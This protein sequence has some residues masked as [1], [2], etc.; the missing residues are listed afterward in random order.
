MDVTDCTSRGFLFLR[1]AGLPADGPPLHAPGL[2]TRVVATSDLR[3]ELPPE[4]VWVDPAR[5]REIHD[6]R[7]RDH[8]Q[9]FDVLEPK[10]SP[11]A[12]QT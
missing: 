3:Q 6:A 1:W 7:E 4:T 12:K 8:A 10:S 11:S 5:R 9:R 2:Q